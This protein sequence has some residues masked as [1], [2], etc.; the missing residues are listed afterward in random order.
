MAITRNIMVMASRLGPCIMASSSDCTT[1]TSENFC[2][3]VG[4]VFFMERSDWHWIRIL[5]H[6]WNTRLGIFSLRVA[7][8]PVR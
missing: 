8:V 1:R 7:V 4:S 3:M 5:A 6:S 2:T